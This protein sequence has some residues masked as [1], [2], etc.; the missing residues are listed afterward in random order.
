MAM[1]ALGSSSDLDSK[2]VAM[3]FVRERDGRAGN[4]GKAQFAAPTMVDGQFA[5]KDAAAYPEWH[6]PGR[7]TTPSLDGTAPSAAGDVDAEAGGT[8]V[9]ENSPADASD[10]VTCH[11]ATRYRADVDPAGHVPIRDMTQET[12]A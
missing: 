12:D 5:A 2:S 10:R 4:A 1:P 3:V 7:S 6:R 11:R 9:L 8:A